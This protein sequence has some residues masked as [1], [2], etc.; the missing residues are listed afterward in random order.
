MRAPGRSGARDTAEGSV[1]VDVLEQMTADRA[2]ETFT[3]FAVPG[4]PPPGP[5]TATEA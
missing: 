2:V 3:L 5:E 1:A 4:G